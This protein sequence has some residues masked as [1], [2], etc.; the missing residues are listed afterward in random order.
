MFKF[1]SHSAPPVVD[2][3]SIARASRPVFRALA[4]AARGGR[5]PLPTLTRAESRRRNR[6]L[7]AKYLKTL[8]ERA[9]GLS[10]GTDACAPPPQNEAFVVGCR[11]M[12][13]IR[14]KEPPQAE[15][16]VS[17]RSCPASPRRAVLRRR[18]DD[19]RPLAHVDTLRRRSEE[20]RS[21]TRARCG[22][23]DGS[24]R[25]IA[26]AP[27][28]VCGVVR[29]LC[30]CLSLP[31]PGCR[32]V[33][34]SVTRDHASGGQAALGARQRRRGASALPQISVAMLQGADRCRLAF[35]IRTT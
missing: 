25:E 4:S 20:G 6:T 32:R 7:V 8:R 35:G 11:R 2:V 24:A 14:P 10:S 19:G 13:R 33:V 15:M 30:G 12:K 9:I 21:I 31:E 18:A 27:S 23:D 29:R 28:L 22:E 3:E 34:F 16:Y 26:V 1:P 5:L 17:L